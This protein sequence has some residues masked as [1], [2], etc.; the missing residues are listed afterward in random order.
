MTAHLLEPAPHVDRQYHA[1][2]V[3]A[4]HAIGAI[5]EGA[6][7]PELLMRCL[8]RVAADSG[9]MVAPTSLMRG[10]CARLQREL[11]GGGRDAAE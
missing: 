1:G 6:S 9:F 3:I 11:S 5:R 2:E 7:D 8:L 4:D 10:V